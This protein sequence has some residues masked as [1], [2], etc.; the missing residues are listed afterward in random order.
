MT[1]RAVRLP[2]HAK[3]N[4]FLRVLAREADGYH[5]LETL[6]CLVDLAD[7]VRA[8]RREGRGVTIDVEGPELGPPAENLAVRA[9]AAV[10]AATGDRFAAHLTLVK[11]IPVRAGL[12]GGSSDAAAALLAV[13]RLAGDAVPRHELLQFAA[14]LGSD[15]PFFLAGAPLALA[16]AHGDRL[17]R[18]PPLPRAPAL[19][20]TPSVPIATAEAYAWVDQ[21]RPSAGRRG[22][23]A[24]DL[25]SLSTWGDIGRMAGN[26][27]ESAV[28]GRH[29][30]VRAAFEALAGTGP[31]VC[32]MTG[33][34][35]A[36]FAVYRSPGDREDARMMLGR[37]HGA[38]TAVETLAG[39]PRGP[40]PM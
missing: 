10:L 28:F 18:L 23:V 9:A 26:D 12:G 7:E 27:F 20:L 13:N 11:R 1:D 2:A 4:L 36:L 14:R 16:W 33:S 37:K 15:V 19:V 17:L 32:R 30:P 24:L 3:L 25:Q 34:G 31:L 39:P 22:A 40:E 29:P 35:S 38:L 5:G 21:D 6:F 8:E